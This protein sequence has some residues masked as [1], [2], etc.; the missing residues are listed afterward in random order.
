MATFKLNKDNKFELDLNGSKDPSD[1]SNANWAPLASGFSQFTP[2][3]NETSDTT[4]Y[5][6]GGGFGS[7]DITGKRLNIAFTG[8]RDRTDAAQNFLDTL[9]LEVGDALKTLL[10]W[11]KPD[12]TVIIGQVTCS[13]LVTSGGSAGAKET[14]SFTAAFNGKPV[15]NES[16]IV[17]V[18]GVTLDKTTL[19][20]KVGDTGKLNATVL[21]IDATDKSTTFITSDASKATIDNSGNYSFASAGTV[22]FTAKTTDGGKLATCSATITEA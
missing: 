15:K 1:V 18:T 4:E 13:A 12:G 22:T 19:S 8:H 14:C 9:E 20:G 10:R 2:S 6:D 16:E 7:T 17:A 3:L 11:T 21:P 5:L